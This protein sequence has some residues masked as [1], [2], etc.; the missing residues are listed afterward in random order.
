MTCSTGE[1]KILP[2]PILPVFA[3]PFGGCLPSVISRVFDFFVQQFG[4]ETGGR[5]FDKFCVFLPLLLVFG[6]VQLI[7]DSVQKRVRTPKKEKK[8]EEPVSAKRSK[9]KKA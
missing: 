4:N 2:S 5:Y 1:T 8:D 9:K 7:V 3:A 6:L